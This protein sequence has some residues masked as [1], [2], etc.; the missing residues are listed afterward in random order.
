MAFKDHFSGHAST[1][2]RYRP[3][4]PQELFDYLATLT[5]R[6]EL[7][8][9]CATGSGQAAVGLARHYECVIATDGSVAQLKSAQPHQHV[10]YLGNLAEQPA[11]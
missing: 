6:H 9:D 5:P 7:A 10:V 8:L 11:L 3:D 1:Y 4:Y 2:A